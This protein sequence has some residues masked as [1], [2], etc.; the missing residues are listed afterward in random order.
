MTA[1]SVFG[2]GSVAGIAL[3][4]G[5]CFAP[6][7]VTTCLHYEAL[8][9]LNLGLRRLDVAGRGRLVLL[10]LGVFV[11]HVAEA[12]LYAS[13]YFLLTRRAGMGTLGTLQPPTFSASVYFSLETYSSLGYGDI[14]PSGTL[15]MMAGAEA[16]NGLLLLGWSA[17]FAHIAMDRF[18]QQSAPGAR[19][20]HATA[21]RDRRRQ[22]HGSR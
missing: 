3:V 9:C 16:L 6:L 18:W 21:M 1:A 8:R 10:I 15:R 17:S 19:P 14:V 11:V 20:A 4:G 2:P 12:L 22:R 7:L 13:V 5:C